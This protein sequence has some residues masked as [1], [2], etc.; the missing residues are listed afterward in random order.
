MLLPSEQSGWLQKSR[1][2]NQV[3]YPFIEIGFP[4]FGFEEILVAN[5]FK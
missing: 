2:L 1:N 5:A 3:S 4:N